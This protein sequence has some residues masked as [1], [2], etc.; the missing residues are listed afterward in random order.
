MS[1]RRLTFHSGETFVC[2][3]G[4]ALTLSRYVTESGGLRIVVGVAPLSETNFVP[5]PALTDRDVA[6]LCGHLLGLSF[7]PPQAP[8]TI[9]EIGEQTGTVSGPA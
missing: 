2:E 8:P 4:G 3:E 7:A 5:V 9:L 6:V 1:D